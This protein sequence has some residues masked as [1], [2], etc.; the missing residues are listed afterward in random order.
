MGYAENLGSYWRGRY[1]AAPGKYATV[2]DDSGDA[3]RFRTKAA[4]KKAADAEEAKLLAGL[5]A[6][7]LKPEPEQITFGAYASRWYE[8]QDLAASTMQNYRRHI[9]EHLLPAF[10]DF[11]IADILKTD[12]AAWEKRERAVPYAASSVKTWR[13]T[14]HLILADA[15]EEGLRDSNPAT[16]RRG[17]G[18][19]AG[20]SRNRGPEKAVTT[21]LGILL[22]AERAALLSGRD[23]EFVALVLKGYTGMRWGEIV[24]LETEY[25]RPK[26]IRVEWQLYELDSGELHRC[27]PKDDSYRDIDSPGFLG[28]L[29]AGHITRARP[30]P[31][32]CH[33]LTYAFSGHGAANGSASRPGAKLVDV[34]RRAGVS[35]GTVSNVLNRPHAVADPTRLKVFAAISELGY[36]RNAA[37]GELAAHWRRSGFATWLF[38]PAATGMYPRRGQ[39]DAH[40]VPLVADPWPGIPAR[41]R[42]AAGRSEMCWLPIAPGLTP[43]GLRHTHKTL[44]R[45]AGTPPKLMDERMGH[46][47]GSVQARYDHITPGMRK[48]LMAALTEMWEEA[49]EKRRAMGSG[50]PVAALDALLK[51]RQ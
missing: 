40:P 20:R 10:E 2:R 25:V 41:G 9:E 47:D 48:S 30:K 33:G 12:I 14:L 28:A 4:A 17:R 21:A 24:G 49:L 15:V 26:G 22:L 8:A 3:I 23:D 36:I 39:N 29:V 32:E 1:K 38:Q 7:V 45:E 51:A 44:M 11:A 34:A 5:K 50:S 16:K 18:K 46:E 42:G 13:A 27:P 37:S 6:A 35:T 43:H 19:R 31:C